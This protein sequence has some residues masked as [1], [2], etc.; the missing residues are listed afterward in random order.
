LEAYPRSFGVEFEPL[1]DQ[2]ISRILEPFGENCE[3]LFA[4]LASVVKKRRHFGPGK[5]WG[6]L[7]T[8]ARDRAAAL[9]ARGKAAR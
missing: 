3:P 4:W 9:A 5:G 1:D 6:I 8:M 2:T 7:V